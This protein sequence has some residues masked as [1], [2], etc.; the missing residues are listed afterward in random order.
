MKKFIIISITI[1]VLILCYFLFEPIFTYYAGREKFTDLSALQ[2]KRDRTDLKKK[3]ADNILK[4]EYSKLQTPALSVS[5]GVNNKLVWANTV[6]YANVNE[7][8]IANSSTKFRIG[9]VSKSFTSVGL[10][11]LIQKGKLEP[12]STVQNFVTYASNK[13]S[14]LTVKQLSSHTSGI[15]NYG[16]CLC[17]PIWEYY[18]NDEYNSIEESIAIFNDDDLLFEPGENFSYSTYNYTLLSGVMEKAA[19]KDFLLF[20]E[21]EVFKPL[22]MKETTADKK[23]TDL[24]N[25]ATFY[26]IEDGK[27][28]Q[29][30]NINNSSKWAGGGFLSTTNDLVKFGNAILNNQLLD[31]NTTALL[32]KPVTIS[33]GEVNNQ[34]YGLGWRNDVK[35]EVL[36][37]HR[38]TRVIHHGGVAIGSTAM[39]ILLP[40]YNTTI[41]VAMNRSGQS[42][43]LI[44]VAYKIA[45]LF[46]NQK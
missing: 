31:A 33:N 2:V 28:S 5:I 29:A 24:S 46:I 12:T 22:G 23:N 10:G 15:R 21:D 1:V 8:V 18:D 26:D 35:E 43:E 13:L 7:Q 37:D 34:N 30:Y 27:I 6:G 14:G 40:K 39:L 44:D 38:K 4:T 19:E 25:V 17:F 36:S 45:E 20:M 11:V 16:T 42:T 32:F 9:S 3:Q 41:A